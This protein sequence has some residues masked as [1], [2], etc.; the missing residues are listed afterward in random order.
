MRRTASEVIRDLE[1]R[2]ARLERQATRHGVSKSSSHN[3]KAFLSGL[4]K[5]VGDF[6]VHLKRS[7]PSEKEREKILS[8]MASDL[9]N[10]LNKDRNLAEE[11]FSKFK[12]EIKPNLLTITYFDSR[13]GKEE[14]NFSELKSLYKYHFRWHDKWRKMFEHIEETIEHPLF[15]PML[16]GDLETLVDRVDNSTREK[17]EKEFWS[18]LERYSSTLYKIL[19][20]LV[21]IGIG[22]YI[23]KLCVSLIMAGVLA[24][25]AKIATYSLMDIL[26]G[27]SAS[28]FTTIAS[29]KFLENNGAFEDKRASKKVP[30]DPEE[31]LELFLELL[32]SE[33]LA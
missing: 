16:Q 14:L 29:M 28:V 24:A 26:A 7:L 13:D 20:V 15:F 22:V 27:I 2:V 12:C 3:K 30:R 19:K 6:Y 4:K 21:K 18:K 11:G 25:A 9:E 31:R 1:M 33:G 5:K 23:L 10:T 8:K 32:E 17:F